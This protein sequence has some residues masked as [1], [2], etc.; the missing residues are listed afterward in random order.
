MEGHALLYLNFIQ[1]G[2]EVIGRRKCFDCVGSLQCCY[3]SELWR[4][5]MGY[6]LYCDSGSFF[7]L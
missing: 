6:I 1:L 3:Q 2:A 7:A 5:K 4:G